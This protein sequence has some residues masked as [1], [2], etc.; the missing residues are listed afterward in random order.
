MTSLSSISTA[1]Q[2]VLTQ[3]QVQEIIGHNVANASTPGYR[4]QAAV[5][6]AGYPSSVDGADHVVGAGQMGGSVIIEKINRFNL[7]FFDGRYRS[8]S[9]ETSSNEAQSG[10]LNQLEATLAETSDDGLLPK[11]DQFWAG[12]QSLSSDPTNTSLRGVLLDD[13]SS[14]ALAFNRR[15]EQINMLRNDQNLSVSSQVDQV[16]SLAEQI[17]K[18]NGEISHVLS[19][20]EQPND[21]MDKRDLALDQLANLTGSVSSEQKNGE[22]MVS[23]GGHVLVVGHETVKLQTKTNQISPNAGM[24]DVY[25]E[26]NQQLVPP[27]GTLKGVLEVRDH[28]LVDQL[29]GLNTMAAG[30]MTQV[31]TIHSNGFGV[32]NSTG[33]AFF[34]GT[35]GSEAGTIA[36]NPLLDAASIATSSSANQAGNNNVALQIAALKTAKGMKAGTSTLNEFYNDQI[37]KLALTTQTA[38]DNT[39]QYGLVAK[40][41]SDQRESVAGVSLDEE[42]ANMA[43][44]QKAYQAAARMLTAFDDLLDLVI[45]RMGRVGL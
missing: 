24:L 33:N 11:L 6:T 41:L 3:S 9:A 25:W 8:V 45:N 23:I 2:A 27:S 5:L 15:V 42:A 10:I 1:L 39:Y 4:R 26:D 20:G 22:M 7:A 28:V 32:N 43:K 16:N 34:V 40:A 13:A 29:A 21:L 19:V 12:W 17:A 36:V 31:N 37:T 30:L 44:T 38:G 14:L 18:L 35:A